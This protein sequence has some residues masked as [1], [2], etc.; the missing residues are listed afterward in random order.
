MNRFSAWRGNCQPCHSNFLCFHCS[1][2]L[3]G[4]FILLFDGVEDENCIGCDDCFSLGLTTIVDC[5]IYDVLYHC[6]S[7]PFP[8]CYHF[9][10]GRVWKGMFLYALYFFFTPL[11]S[12]WKYLGSTNSTSC[13]HY[14]CKL[15]LTN[16]KTFSDPQR[17]YRN[18]YARSTTRSLL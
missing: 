13:L 9:F 4:V 14:L 17:G 8:N 3:S 12:F 11:S 18:T 16:Q 5:V 1:G 15:L 7:S 10:T 6:F 2:V